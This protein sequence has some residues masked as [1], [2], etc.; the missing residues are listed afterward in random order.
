MANK[1]NRTVILGSV[2]LAAL[3]LAGG[4][5]IGVMSAKRRI[6]AAIAQV[7]GLKVGAWSVDPASMQVK[8][9]DIKLKQQGMTLSADALTI[10]LSFGNIW[11][12]A[13]A[14]AAGGTASADNIAIT[15]P[16]FTL[17]IPHVTANDASFDDAALAKMLDAKDPTPASQRIAGLT[18]GSISVPVLTLSQKLPT[19]TSVTTVHDIAMSDVVH[20]IIAHATI[21]KTAAVINANPAVQGTEA[22]DSMS[23]DQLSLPVYLHWMVDTRKDDHEPR[24]LAVAGEKFT[25]ISLHLTQKTAKGD[26]TT[27]ITVKDGDAQ[28]LFM[29]AMSVPV[30]KFASTMP[31]PKPGQPLDAAAAQR[32]FAMEA[33]LFGST[34]FD[35]I[36]ANDIAVTVTGAAKD[37]APAPKPINVSVDALTMGETTSPTA[38]PSG[39]NFGFAH[40]KTDLDQ[41]PDSPGMTKFKTDFYSKLDLSLSNAM[42]WDLA[43]GALNLNDLTISGVG[44]GSA[45]V[46]LNLTN[47]GETLLS[48]KPA[49]IEAAFLTAKAT[50]L[51]VHLDNQGLVQKI[52][53]VRAAAASQTPEQFSQ[54]LIAGVGAMIPAVLGQSPASQ[55]ISA[56]LTKFLGDPKNIDITATSKDG[57]GAAEVM[58]AKVAGPAAIVSKLDIK[59]SANQ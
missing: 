6:A 43:S 23:L 25:G 37:G 22:I 7:P 35:H 28:N 52:M 24:Q 38:P 32:I 39:F 1:S 9:R 59:A 11:A 40:V 34:S 33:D 21:G 14:K 31:Q 57:I 47:V 48:T 20:G 50:A 30:V 53:S 45:T 4:G 29:R 3:A 8:I 17:N 18:A 54:Q 41:F 2:G 12:M 5:T 51:H 44:V 56:A 36:V 13:S 49:D 27:D 15:T 55:S 58:A 42:S 10:P 19:G 26:V 16:A 46:S